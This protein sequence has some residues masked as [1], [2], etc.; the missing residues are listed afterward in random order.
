MGHD[1][2]ASD[3]WFS[4]WK[5]RH[6]I[7]FKK[8]HGEKSS[9]DPTGAEECCSNRLSQLL[10]EYSLENI[11]NADETELFYRA[12]PDGSLTYKHHT[13]VGSKKAMDR[14][15]VLCCCNAN[16]GEKRPLFVI[17]KSKKPKVF[18]TI[19]VNTRTVP[20]NILFPPKSAIDT[21]L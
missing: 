10:D 16:G 6:E 13:L 3:G 17:G 19:F 21:K 18:R 5:V 14:V 20:I 11:F 8:A 1:E 2:V 9:A 12:T 4:R 15:T 7:V